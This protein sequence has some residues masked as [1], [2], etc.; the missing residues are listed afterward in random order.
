MVVS[1]RCSI[2]DSDKEGDLISLETGW[3]VWKEPEGLG[4][5]FGELTMKITYITLFCIIFYFHFTDEFHVNI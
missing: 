4:T 1:M 2:V 5:N 3:K